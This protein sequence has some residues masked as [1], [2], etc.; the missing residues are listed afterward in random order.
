MNQNMQS[1]PPT[2]AGSGGLSSL[3]AEMLLSGRK[4]KE[5]LIGYIYNLNYWKFLFSFF[6]KQSL[7]LCNFRS[8]EYI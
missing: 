3:E 2:S 5:T 4:E 1:H 7:T 8:K 6:L